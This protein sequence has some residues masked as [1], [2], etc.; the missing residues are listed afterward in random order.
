LG[1]YY[2]RLQ[3]NDIYNVAPNPP[4]N[5]LATIF[6]SATAPQQLVSNPGGGTTAT[7]PPQLTVYDAAYPTAS[8]FQYNFGVQRRLASSVVADISYVGTHGEHLSDTR[9]INQPFLAGAAQVL[10]RTANVNQVCPYPG[11][12]AILQY[13]N[14][15]N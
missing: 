6:N 15:A 8:M 1:I 3:G 14:G 5:N 4:F 10:A 9:N 11:Y 13:F 12:A 2:E 7:L